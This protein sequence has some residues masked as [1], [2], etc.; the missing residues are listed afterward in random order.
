MKEQNQRGEAV[1]AELLTTKQAAQLCGL[2]E[3]TLWRYSRSGIAPRPI[4][5]GHGRQGAV[6][7]RKSE[8]VAW[9]EAGCPRTGGPGQ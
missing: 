8:L 9:I 5:L 1:T 2:G 7:F 4:K 6:R 3:R